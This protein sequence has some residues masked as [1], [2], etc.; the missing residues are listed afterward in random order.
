MFP[1]G[2]AVHLSIMTT[3]ALWKYGTSLQ[4]VPGLRILFSLQ[5]LCE[6][7][8]RE[9][10][11]EREREGRPVCGLGEWVEA[12]GPW[13]LEGWRGIGHCF[14]WPSSDSG[15]QP[16][17][18]GLGAQRVASRSKREERL[19]CPQTVPRHPP[20]HHFQ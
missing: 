3:A 14:W 13:V 2:K 10:P 5:C 11:G 9:I 19:W 16:A 7:R 17:A 1:A 15:T 8:R 20:S 4:K 12:P 18:W 6:S